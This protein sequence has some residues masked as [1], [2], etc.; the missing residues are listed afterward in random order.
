MS[1]HYSLKPARCV[2][3]FRPS[4]Q[5]SAHGGQL[6]IAALFTEFDLW[7]RVRQEAALDPRSD[8]CKG[9]DAEIYVASFLFSFT[10]GG[11]SLNDAERL[12]QDEAL[13]ALLG[14][15]KVPDQNT[16]GEWLRAIGEPGWKALRRLSREFVVWTLKR[17]KKERLLVNEWLECFFDDSQIEVSGSWFEGAAINYEGHWALSWQ[18]LWVGPF[19]VDGVL[20]ATSERKES[21]ASE[22]AGRDVS[23]QLP[24]LL[25][26]NRAVWKDYKSYLYADSASSAGT[27]LEAI[28]EAFDGWSV[29]YNKWTS[30]LEKAAAELPAR[31]W[32]AVE[33]LRW[34]DGS[35]HQ[36]QY[37]WYRYQPSGC[38]APQLFAVV[39]HREE[40]EWLWRH[41]FLTCEER[42]GDAKG[43]FERHR[44][45]GDWERR[46]SELLSD[47]GLHHPP[48]KN[49]AA[50]NCF[51]TLASLAYNALV[52]LKLL[53]LPDEHQ[54][55][56]VRTLIHQL[57]LIPV[58]IGRHARQIKA[59]L[60][61]PAVWVKWW[62][63][64][65][66][67]LLPRWRQLGAL[68]DS[69]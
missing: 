28:A 11:L 68:A 31:A 12:D 6:A 19:L 23:N 32:S 50:N 64:F 56:R 38:D 4:S 55:K 49:L 20:G 17:A 67:E 13:R 21:M 69:G 35:E 66:K 54:P 27:Y 46:L 47:L 15:E 30:P 34:R 37:A 8:K 62:R 44:L 51:Y 57:L 5:A 2:I 33:S 45:K 43:A 14:V 25:E 18:S 9:Y 60:Y 24:S 52:A 10:S 41:A 7:R 29:S 63:E 42:A 22:S 65:L 26:S 3:E 40:G 59:S 1:K 16:L 58:E 36:A 53:Y 39:R 48:C 61:A